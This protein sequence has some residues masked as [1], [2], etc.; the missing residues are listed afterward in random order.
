V[1]EGHVEWPP[2]PWR[3]LRALVACGFTTQHWRETPPVAQGLLEKL[4]ETLPAYRLPAANAA[5][6]RHFMPVGALDKG[7]ERTTLVF[8]TWADVGD[9]ELIVRWDCELTEDETQLLRN[10]ADCLGYLGRSESWVEAELIADEV[11]P[12]ADFNAFPHQDGLRPGMQWEQISLM[13]AIPPPEYV[14]WQQMMT[15]QLLAALPLPEDKKKSAAKQ[16]KKVQEHRDIA[17]APYPLN[18]LDCLTKDTAWWKG[19]SWSQP[20][21]SQRVIYWRRNDALQVGVPQRSKPRAAEPVTTMLLSLTTPSG[22][23]SALPPCHRTLPQAELFH[24][25]VVARAGKGE[26]VDCPEL[27]G[28]DERGRPL[29]D[30]HRHAHILPVDLDGDGHLDHVIVHAV[31]GLRE[32]AQ[33]AIRAVRHTWMKGGAST[34]Q[35]AVA[36]SGDL[37]M[38]RSLSEPLDRRRIEQ[39]LGP[40]AGARIWVS[41]T[42]FVPSRFLKRRGSNSL[43]GQINA[44]LAS[45][46]LPGVERIE[47]LT[48]EE[49]WHS[50][51]HFVRSRKRGGTPPPVD[52]GYALRLHFAEPLFGP[53]WNEKLRHPLA[54]GY[55]SHFGLG[56]FAAEE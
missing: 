38:L 53:S 5:H 1:N 11:V 45:R 40:P 24:R 46:G 10:L 9:D 36:G 13:A 20:P 7:R 26:H 12:S 19:H 15:T 42:P 49:S 43:F 50:L 44:E 34:L 3:L 17:V 18:L 25:A 51:R 31:M 47:D 6:S 14:A 21:G 32:T 55:A 35:V 2:S 23:R 22:N 28:R 16:V 37:D 8:D 4:A 52:Y 30:R 33:R 27:T 29:H 39:L 56:L 54:L 41:I 48:R